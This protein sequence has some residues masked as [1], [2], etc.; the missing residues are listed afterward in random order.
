MA[1][2]YIFQSLFLNF[3][4]TSIHY[5]LSISYYRALPFKQTQGKIKTHIF[6]EVPYEC[7]Y[8]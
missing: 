1:F 2:F 5:S 3:Q 7:Q 4:L 6:R 8:G